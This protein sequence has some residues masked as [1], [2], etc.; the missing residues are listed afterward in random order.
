ME[1]LK[2]TPLRKAIYDRL[3][4]GET[5]LRIVRSMNCSN[6]IGYAVQA[7]MRDGQRPPADFVG[8]KRDR[9]IWSPSQATCPFTNRFC[10]LNKCAIW[11]RVE[12]RCSLLS[13][14]I[15]LRKL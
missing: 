8:A 10:D 13:I 7:A 3:Q 2:W 6:A 15:S 9:R 12:K 1:Q 5:V 14:A 11:D 4:T